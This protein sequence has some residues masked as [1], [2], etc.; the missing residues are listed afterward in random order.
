MRL[1]NR[2]AVKVLNNNEIGP[3]N[4]I[5]EVLINNG[6]MY[7]DDITEPER[8]AQAA[9]AWVDTHSQGTNPREIFD[10]ASGWNTEAWEIVMD[11]EPIVHHPQKIKNIFAALVLLAKEAEIDL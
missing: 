10:K 9:E 6:F 4:K 7:A 2:D 3:A 8:Y 11:K 1:T 5:V